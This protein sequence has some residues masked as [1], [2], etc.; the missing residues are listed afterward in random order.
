[1][2][3]I[4]NTKSG[5]R[6]L[7]ML[8]CLFFLDVYNAY[9]INWHNKQ[10]VLIGY[11]FSLDSKF[12]KKLLPY[13]ELFPEPPKTVKED[14]IYSFFKLISYEMLKN[15]LQK[16]LDLFILPVNVYGRRFDYDSYGFPKT[17]IEKAQRWGDAKYYLKV[18]I[19]IEASPES[20]VFGSKPASL[21]TDLEPDEYL[22]PRVK[23]ELT[24]YKSRG[25]ISFASY[26]STMQWQTPLVLEP[27][28]LDG[29]VN[30]QDR[31]DMRTL[32]EALNLGMSAIVEEIE[33]KK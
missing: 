13:D 18:H 3:Y 10:V 8:V 21:D 27:T 22:R 1:M 17:S 5:N 20:G 32:R 16:E 4:G 11:S 12:S 19:G 7:I 6:W 29:L 28:V 25:V 30:T 14:R 2:L 26:S 24:F 9:A 23:V 31:T 15:T 33:K